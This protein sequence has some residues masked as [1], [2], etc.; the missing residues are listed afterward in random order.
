L[1]IGDLKEAVHPPNLRTSSREV[2]AG[3]VF[4]SPADYNRNPDLDSGW[5][6]SKLSILEEG[7]HLVVPL[8]FQSYFI[9][10]AGAAAALAG[11]LFVAASLSR[12][13]LG[14]GTGSAEKGPE[15]RAR[16][17]RWR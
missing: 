14:S 11:L 12:S 2:Q 1:W 7:D 8:E 15:R 9:A 10:S 17:C 13:P 16:A 6:P 4:L 3:L 5:Q